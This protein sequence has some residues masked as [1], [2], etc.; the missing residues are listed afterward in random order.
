ML[1]TITDINQGR[2][3]SFFQLLE[4]KKFTIEIPIIQRDYA[5]GRKSKGEVRELFLQ[6]LYEYLEVGEPNKDLDFVYGSI[7]KTK[8]GKKFIPL[9][10]QQRLTTLFLLHW[11][12]ANISGK[13]EEFKQVILEGKNSKFT[14]L[15]RTSSSEF[16]D[17]LLLNSVDLKSLLK[18]ED[19]EESLSKTIKDFGWYFLSWGY[20]PTIQSM[21]T[22]LD[23]IHEKFKNKA[24][25]YDRLVNKDNPVITFLYM[26][27]GEFN[28]TEDLYIK[29]NSRGKPLTPF[30]NLKAKLEQ[31]IDGFDG[32]FTKQYTL[33]F[34]GVAK[35]V[36]CKDYF[37][38]CVDTKWANL[39]WQYRSLAGKDNTF[40]EELMNFIRVVISNQYALDNSNLES[41]KMLVKADTGEV[42]AA[43]YVSFNKY[44][45][46]NALSKNS[47]THL[48]N[49][50][51]KLENGNH[52]ISVHLIDPFYYNENEV[53]EK[54]LTHKVSLQERVL[55]YAYTSYLIANPSDNSG[56]QDWMRV[57]H[58][59]T[60]NTRIEE[61]EN[62][63]NAIKSVNK[64][65]V[66]SC[67]ILEFLTRKNI[68]VDFF[69]SR[70]LQEER[71]KSFLIKK[72]EVWKST[73]LR[74]ERRAFFKGQ[75]AFLFDFTGILNYFE[76]NDNCNWSESD[77]SKH[78]DEFTRYAEKASCLFEIIGTDDNKDYKLERAVLT[79]GKYLIPAANYRFNFCSSSTAKNYQRDLSWKRLLRMPLLN[80]GI[81]EIKIWE[82]RRGYIKNTINDPLF[83][84]TNVKNSLTDLCKNI[85]LGWRKYFVENPA[86]FKYCLQGFIGIYSEFEIELFKESS[87]K[88]KH[89]DLRIYDFYLKYVRNYTKEHYISL[90]EFDPFLYNSIIEVRGYD[91]SKVAL[92]EWCYKK[93]YYEVQINFEELD[94]KSKGR[95]EIGFY[96]SKG[97]QQL[98]FFASDIVDILTNHGF[99]WN[100]EYS[101]F[102][103]Y[104]NDEFQT[105]DFVK[106]LCADL[107]KL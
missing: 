30:E 9:D 31:F 82:E 99:T 48:I 75:L 27:L 84:E 107:N 25:W 42:D 26:D 81:E 28:L 47:I 29:M 1:N 6:A 91:T 80:A 98:R 53:F 103:I 19:G 79:K 44:F 97:D 67:N 94:D 86:L 55:F 40:D 60:E 35:K 32:S 4:D 3:Y 62:A 65:L 39:F 38:F 49:V 51:D 46:I 57:I 16:C 12:L 73:I 88:F 2:R 72:S 58:N 89:V 7:E 71:L 69:F 93:I 24:G 52:K 102:S 50:F 17:A 54:V 21:I 45:N 23:A 66:E 18:N 11:Y 56:L 87:I 36:S 34:D 74:Y 14:Y 95:F 20:D 59:L 76:S 78:F 64:L 105:I 33:I 70:Q 100:N 83:V 41:Y 90:P 61:A 13:M 5:Q 63:V 37:S 43:D 96:K 92:H 68:K 106:S 101:Y 15:T 8:A 10:G 104:Q 77:N 22:M 85:P